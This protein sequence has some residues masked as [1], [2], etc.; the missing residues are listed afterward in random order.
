MQWNISSIDTVHLTIISI[1]HYIVLMFYV[2][3]KI[4]NNLQNSW[5]ELLLS[6]KK[7]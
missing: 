7:I 2:T 5:L 3:Y 4:E 1:A 6:L